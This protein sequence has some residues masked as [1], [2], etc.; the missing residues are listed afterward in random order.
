M[1]A[2]E[3]GENGH[4]TMQWEGHFFFCLGSAKAAMVATATMAATMTMTMMA[5]TVQ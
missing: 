4:C 1:T 2:A 3:M 5:R